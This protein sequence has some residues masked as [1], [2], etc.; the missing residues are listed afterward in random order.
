MGIGEVLDVESTKLE[1][2]VGEV[3]LGAI[4]H[5]GIEALTVAHELLQVHLADDLAHLAEHDLGDLAGHLLLVHV[6]VVLGG[7][8]NQIG[9]LPDLEI[10]HGAGVD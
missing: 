2:E 5:L 6:Q 7:G 8:L 1:T 4:E 10:R 3:I 9:S